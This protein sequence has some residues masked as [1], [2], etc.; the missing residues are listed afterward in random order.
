MHGQPPSSLC[1]LDTTIEALALGGGG[2]GGRLRLPRAALASPSP[3]EAH[4]LCLAACANAGQ[5]DTHTNRQLSAELDSRL[6]DFS[7]EILHSQG[8]SFLPLAYP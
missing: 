6:L 3:V 7:T 1:H 2:S 5:G 8:L 4:L